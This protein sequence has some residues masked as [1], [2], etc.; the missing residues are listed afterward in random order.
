AKVLGHLV[1]GGRIIRFLMSQVPNARHAN[2]DDLKACQ[3]GLE[4]L[5]RLEIL[6]GDINKHNF[7]MTGSDVTIIDFAEAKRCTDRKVLE[8]EM[9]GLRASLL[10]ESGIGGRIV[11]DTTSAHSPASE[12]PAQ[13]N[14]SNP[15]Y[16]SIWGL[17][18]RAAEVS[19]VDAGN[20]P[21]TWQVEPDG[22]IIRGQ[23]PA[24]SVKGLTFENYTME[25]SNKIMKGGIGWTI[26]TG[27]APY[28]AKFYL[29]TNGDSS[30]LSSY[31]NRT[32]QPVDTLVF[33]YGWGIVN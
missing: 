12:L 6:H 24:Q 27:R 32:L 1:E 30:D 29:T 26:G 9:Q 15:T 20:A 28:G 3:T 14:T 7:L 19:C 33:N 13:L 25:F 11:L 5:H 8:E 23:A 17:G 21:S 22:T 2:I 16:D 10:D 18:A 4:K 31:V